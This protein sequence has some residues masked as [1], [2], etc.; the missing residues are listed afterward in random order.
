MSEIYLVNGW[1][2]SAPFDLG[3]HAPVDARPD[4]V[5]DIRPEALDPGAAR[6]PLA[7]R[8][9]AHLGNQARYHELV[10]HDPDHAT[11]RFGD[12]VD[13]AIDLSGH[14]SETGPT[15]VEARVVGGADQSLIPLLVAGTL[16]SA[17]L[18]LDGHMVL[19]ASA[20]EVEGRTVAF[21]GTSGSGKSTLAT[22]A[23]L[24]GARLVS[25]DVLRVGVIDGV[26]VCHRGSTHLRLRQGA[27]VLLDGSDHPDER[28]ADGRR[29]FAPATPNRPVV[30]LDAVVLPLL[31]APE[32]AI[33]PTRLST[34]QALFALLGAPRVSNW[35]DPATSAQHL[36]ALID[37]VERVPVYAVEI[38]WGIGAGNTT[39]D[40]IMAVLWAADEP[41]DD[42]AP[43]P[44]P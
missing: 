16:L 25:D 32:A 33:T 42:T 40:Q 29:A 4:V 6:Q 19:H 36:A 2:V 26:A 1:V 5:V 22:M 15:V 24:A 11:L 3:H 37:L 10:M 21:V 44:T 9:I 7:G 35:S 31:C 12:L 23:C 20:V 30:P 41:T 43:T 28:T 34:R 13:F 39:I 27:A 18:M 14:R 8:V 38:P 17:M